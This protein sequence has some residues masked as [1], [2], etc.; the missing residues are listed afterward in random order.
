M[1]LKYV[2]IF[3]IFWIATWARY[4]LLLEGGCF[5]MYFNLVFWPIFE[6]H[7]DLYDPRNPIP[8]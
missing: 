6:F 2:N 8:A 1:F 3:T 4:Y 7:D 5:F